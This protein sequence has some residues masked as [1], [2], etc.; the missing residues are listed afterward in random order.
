MKLKLLAL[1]FCWLS[2]GAMA[3]TTYYNNCGTASIT[4]TSGTE[5]CGPPP[6]NPTTGAITGPGVYTQSA[7]YQDTCYNSTGVV[8]ATQST[9]VSGTGQCGAKSGVICPPDFTYYINYAPSYQASPGGRNQFVEKAYNQQYYNSGCADANPATFQQTTAYC[10][11]TY[12][13]PYIEGGGGGCAVSAPQNG[14][15]PLDEAPTCPIDYPSGECYCPGLGGPID[16]PE[17][18][19]CPLGLLVAPVPLCRSAVQ[20]KGNLNLSLLD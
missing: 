7:T 9:T 3:Q 11:A 1:V 8:T 19:D 15:V 14:T 18:S 10:A 20:R 12:C 17:C 4:E 6:T 2:L 13:G 16:A 5:S